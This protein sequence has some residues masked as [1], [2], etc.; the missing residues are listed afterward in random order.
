M[1]AT[2]EEKTQ[3]VAA[4]KRT[5]EDY[6]TGH[7]EGNMGYKFQSRAVME[8]IYLYK[9]GVDVRNP[10]LLGVN[11]KNTFVYEAQSEIE[12]IKE[13]V[14]LDIVDMGFQVPGASTLGRFIPKAANR[15]M[16]EENDFAETL[17]QVPDDA[18]DYGSG[19]LKI[20]EADNEMKIRSIDPFDMIF[21]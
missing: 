20:W 7:L 15:K 2:L 16:L 10:D 13:Q 14:R 1:K 17:D 19:F 21:N 12:K 11:N 18:I 8:V 4:A 9:H 3:I 6:L 5:I